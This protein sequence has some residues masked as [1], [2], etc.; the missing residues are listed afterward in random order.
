MK[1]YCSLFFFF[2]III[3]KSQG[4]FNVVYEADYKLVYKN[5]TK[6]A[7]I[8]DAAFA[9]LMNEKE[10]YYK[11]INQY[12]GDSLRLEKK[13]HEN[14][15]IDEQ[16]KYISDFPENIGTTTGKIY[17]TFKTSNE[18][19]K[20]EETNNINWQLTNDFKTIGKYKCQKAITKKY[21]RTWIAYFT[22][23][24]PFPFGP[25]K[26]SK[27]PGLIL[28]VF[29][30]KDDYHFTMYNFKKRKYYC[31]S[32]NLHSNAKPV[33]KEKIFDYQR[34][35]LTD[36]TLYNKFIEDTE[37]RRSLLKKAGSRAKNYNPIELSIY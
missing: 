6:N 19:F 37:E 4:G 30:D 15:P 23:E 25:Y 2:F 29:D 11:N 12:V 8:Q 18:Y 9:L 13:L 34:K 33:K 36:P 32:A 35:E 20:Y 10:S 22:K 1:I 5:Q 28:E 14:S 26:F 24:I 16:M 7:I 17:V 21:G 31:I 27:L 3:I